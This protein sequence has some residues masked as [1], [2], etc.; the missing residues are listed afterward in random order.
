VGIVAYH[1][2]RLPEAYLHLS[3]CTE[4]KVTPSESEAY[5]KK[6][7]EEVKN[8]LE[9]VRKRVGL[10]RV[11]MGDGRQ[12]AVIVIDGKTIGTAPLARDVA[13]D[14][15]VTHRVKATLGTQSAEDE[16]S[17]PAG[18][19]RTAYLVLSPPRAPE[20]PEPTTAPIKSTAPVKSAVPVAST[21][22]VSTAPSESATPTA[23][24][25][26]SQRSFPGSLGRSPFF[27]SATTIAV[28]GASVTIG[29]HVASLDARDDLRRAIA[30]PSVHGCGQPGPP[31]VD[32]GCAD[33]LDAAQ[34]MTTARLVTTTSLLVSGSLASATFMAAIGYD[35]ATAP[36]QVAKA[37]GGIVIRGTF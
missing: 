13:L 23:K 34:S 31:I 24:A 32:G 7:F 15:W 30:N 12:G 17:I 20:S 33:Y 14:P 29:A 37:V 3:I 5:N 10:L 16:L 4:H 8:D 9:D 26:A 22:P 1:L 11:Q 36:V 2:N 28:I 27:W 6:F 25:S 19:T 21:A 18:Q 35:L